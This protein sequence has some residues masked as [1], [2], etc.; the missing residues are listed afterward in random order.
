MSEKFTILIVCTGN[1]C[2]SPMAEGALRMLL[3]KERPGRA[4]VLS[5]GT[6]AASGFPATLY[7]QEAVKM[8]DLDISTHE[9]RPLTAQLIGQAD[10]VFAMSPEHLVRIVRLAPE[11][12]SKTYLFKNF[13]D[14]A[15]DGEAVDDPIGQAL[16][17]YN[18]VFLEIAE[19]LGKHLPE[20]VKRI[21]GRGDG[22]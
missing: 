5:A 17:R 19:Y 13:P 22:N 9:S 2:R 12:A 6:A 4:E 20:L 14:P 16:D 10:L 11:A 7:A 18:V 3:E 15:T 8:W 1:T 21:D